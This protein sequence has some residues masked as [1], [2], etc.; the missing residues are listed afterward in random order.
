[1]VYVYD[2]TCEGFQ[3]VEFNTFFINAVSKAIDSELCFY[4]E[5]E[6]GDYV[7]ERL[8]KEGIKISYKERAVFNEN[9]KIKR[10]L[11]IFK[12]YKNLINSAKNNKINKIVVTVARKYEVVILNW[13]ARSF[14]GKIYM[15]FHAHL[16]IVMN[17]NYYRNIIANHTANNV[18]YI[19]LSK[20]IKNSMIEV[21][22][23]LKDKIVA[24]HH[25]LPSEGV[26][27]KHLVDLEHI[28]FGFIGIAT[29]EKGMRSICN[30]VNSVN[31][32]NA[33]FY[34]CGV[35]HDN[36]IIKQLEDA[37][38]TVKG[39]RTPL[40]FDQYKES[41][42]S[43]D[44]VVLL[45]EPKAYEYRVSGTLIDAVNNERPI[46]V[47]SNKYSDEVF[48]EFG[49]IGYLCKDENEI[50]VRIRNIL[51]RFS[52]DEYDLQVDA[53]RKMKCEMTVDVVVKELLGL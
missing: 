10:F 20:S 28:R 31:S 27:D 15:L 2:P 34:Y 48:E 23:K 46:I 32:K 7:K 52:Q 25:A 16:S 38:V 41:I 8:E 26:L 33:G 12:E 4:S 17:S 1:M 22:P 6:H 36:G 3:H 11:R 43:L 37:G 44:Y 47:L 29:Q 13:L 18:K 5:K 53:M 45:L 9:N 50:N 51:G 14:E 42:R 19:V 21:A 24:I 35:I 40:S 39:G 49:E 30:I